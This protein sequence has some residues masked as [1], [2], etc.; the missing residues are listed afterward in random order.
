MRRKWMRRKGRGGKNAEER[1][2]RKG[3]GR[4]EMSKKRGGKDEE[5]ITRREGQG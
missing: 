5:K 2:K 1:T 3:S 4:K